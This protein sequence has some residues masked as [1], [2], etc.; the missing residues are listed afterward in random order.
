M[1]REFTRA[2][3]NIWK[4]IRRMDCF[5]TVDDNVEYDTLE[6]FENVLLINGEKI[7]NQLKDTINRFPK[8]TW[9]RRKGKIAT[10]EIEENVK[11]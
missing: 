11:G 9:K 8:N 6:N 5:N 3:G 2:S 10:K 1:Q 7:T 4:A